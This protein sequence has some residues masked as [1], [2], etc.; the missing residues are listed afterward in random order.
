MKNSQIYVSRN[1]VEFGPFFD[2][3]IVEF[4]ARGVLGGSDHLRVHGEN[5][6]LEVA[7]WLAKQ[8]TVKPDKPAAKTAAK[9]ATAR[10]TA[11]KKTAKKPAAS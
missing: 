7:E 6:W 1:F 11:A 8:Q 4:Q 2:Y 9:K 10:K 3:E 5:H